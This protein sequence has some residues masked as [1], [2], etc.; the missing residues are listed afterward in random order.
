MSSDPCKPIRD[1]IDGLEA[2]VDSLQEELR[3]APPGMKPG[4]IK[5]IRETREEIGDLRADL[6]SC[7]QQNP[8]Q[9]PSENVVLTTATCPICAGEQ[10]RVWRHVALEQLGV[11]G[12]DVDGHWIGGFP[13]ERFGILNIN[14]WY[15]LAV[16]KRVL[17]GT[18][19]HFNFYDGIGDEADWNN[20]VIPNPAFRPMLE[21]PKDIP[22]NLDQWHDCASS[23]DCME[24][25]I[26]PDESYYENIFNSRALDSSPLEGRVICAYGPWIR[27]KVHN[28]RPEIHPSEMYW[29]RGQLPTGQFAYTLMMVQDD[30]NRFDREENFDFGAPWDDPPS[31]WRAW[32]ANP[33]TNRF[34]IAFELNPSAAPLT[35]RIS[36]LESLRVL[37]RWGDATP[38]AEHALEYNGRVVLRI[39][40]LLPNEAHLGVML[41]S[42]C[43][44]AAN[45]RLQGYVVLTATVGI[46][47]RGGE[48]YQ[49]LMVQVGQRPF[50]N[51]AVLGDWPVL[52][53][54]E[55]QGPPIVIA[56]TARPATLRRVVSDGRPR[57][58]G[59]I[60]VRIA[61]APGQT[62]EPRDLSIASADLVS[63]GERRRVTHHA[64]SSVRGAPVHRS[65]LD[66]VA[67][68]ERGRLEVKLASGD[69]L[70]VE[71]P[72]LAIAPRIAR[73]RPQRTTRDQDAWSVLAKAAGARKDVATAPVS[74]TRA[75]R[76]QIDAVAE[77]APV[78]AGK[79][80]AED[81][82]PFVEALNQAAH[83]DDRTRARRLFGT[84]RPLQV[85][86][87]FEAVNLTTGAQVPVREEAGESPRA[88][89]VVTRRPGG[90]Q[91]SLVVTFPEEPAG[92]VFELTA[93]AR[94]RD[95]F[96]IEG[97]MT[98]RVWSHALTH[99]D[100][101]VLARSTAE[102]AALLAGV[103]P[104]EL[105]RASDLGEPT[106]DGINDDP[107]VPNPRA[108][109]ATMVQLLAL[110]AS[111]DRRVT[112][113]EL[114][115]LISTARTFDA[116]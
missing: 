76:W 83:G 31:N 38:G 14:N 54:Q 89:H 34:R 53:S 49:T 96:G 63:G 47:D 35:F 80:S 24:A 7:E 32:S 75:R 109:R 114:R 44:N 61:R 111:E 21:D 69:I 99:R 86:W 101:R 104:G 23:N 100:P 42:I 88:V 59:D 82:T 58:V 74:V 29:W 72:A 65:V 81:D 71:L 13:A 107:R 18:L 85:D 91:P 95:P 27:E 12:V 102:T 94:M 26:T 66:G 79:P 15:P 78:R 33:R 20:F 28:N 51:D 19:H 110:A 108:T 116:T 115:G 36:H 62:G 50:F 9:P 106:V 112:V 30:S 11:D 2:M 16:E 77:Y 84:A 98:H 1:E 73:E 70:P 37:E 92:A 97:E 113:D 22:D 25:E 46:G 45:D 5:M 4:L 40:E 64:I 60:D 6:R 57:L 39:E 103:A 56:A 17:C 41:G 68:A 48:G 10:E 67:V 93:T 8:P 55:R 90:F 43:R 52:A 87:T 105:G 3:T